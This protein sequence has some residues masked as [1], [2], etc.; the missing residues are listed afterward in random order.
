MYKELCD[1]LNSG[2]VAHAVVPYFTE[3]QAILEKVCKLIINSCIHICVILGKA[4][5]SNFPYQSSTDM[6]ME[7]EE[8]FV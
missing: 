8:T 5:K 3:L 4:R 1:K 6:P 7:G 2:S